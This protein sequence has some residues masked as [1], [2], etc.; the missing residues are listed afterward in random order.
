MLYFLLGKTNVINRL[1]EIVYKEILY[2]I[3]KENLD[4]VFLDFGILFYKIKLFKLNRDTLFIM[5]KQL[6]VFQQ[7]SRFIFTTSFI[8][9][10]LRKLFRY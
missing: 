6:T 3:S 10:S 4:K 9:L 8:T 1:D 7:I 2:K 5:S